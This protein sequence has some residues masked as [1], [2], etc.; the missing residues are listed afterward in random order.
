MC[1]IPTDINECDSSPCQNGGTCEDQVNGYTCHCLSGY[2]GDHC[3]A[4][5][6]IFLVPCVR[7]CLLFYSIDAFFFLFLF[8][9]LFNYILAFVM[10]FRNLGLRSHPSIELTIHH[11]FKPMKQLCISNNRSEFYPHRHQRMP[12]KSLSE[13]RDL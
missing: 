6:T 8:S 3:Q 10:K 12:Q 2:N 11:L 5:N 13:R 1:F 7:S 9:F 4:G